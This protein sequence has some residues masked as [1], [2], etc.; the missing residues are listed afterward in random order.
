LR[1]STPRRATFSVR[2]SADHA[3][4]AGLPAPQVPACY[5]PSVVAAGAALGE[6]A[7]GLSEAERSALFAA[8]RQR[9][10][11]RNAR[12]FCE[13]DS[14]DFIVVII[15]GRVKIVVT[16][17]EGGESLL[18]VRGPGAL[19]GELAAF[20]R[21]PRGASV[22]ALEP[23]TVRLLAADE[24]RAF[25]AQQ[26]EAGL[27]LIRVLIGRLREADRRR[28]EFGVYDSVSRVAR[29]LG[30]LI[31]GQPRHIEV[32]LT[33]QEIAGLVGASRESVARALGVLR[34]R[35]LVATGRRTITVLDPEALRSVA[36]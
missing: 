27:E 31:D 2:R 26:P 15:E 12:V 17:A 3:G 19:V 6:F 25:I 35:H 32:R 13:G 9:T 33:Q 11:P 7:D 29:L 23:L 5:R 24:F 1:A 8:G 10:Y 36:G 34:S 22:V 20:D 28:A 21:G 18:G 14:S 30:D 4:Q 16:T